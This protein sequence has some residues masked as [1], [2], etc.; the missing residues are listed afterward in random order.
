MDK[1]NGIDFSLRALRQTTAMEENSQILFHQGWQISPA[2]MYLLGFD[3]SW[4]VMREAFVSPYDQ[5][6]YSFNEAMRIEMLVHP[7]QSIISSVA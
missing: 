1:Q 7:H 6:A 4:L 3:I 2:P 5:K